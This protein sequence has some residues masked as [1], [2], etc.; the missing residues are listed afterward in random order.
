M[1]LTMV[2]RILLLLLWDSLRTRGGYRS[3]SREGWAF[4]PSFGAAFPAVMM[5]IS[6]HVPQP[7]FVSFTS[8]EPELMYCS[9]FCWKQLCC[10][11]TSEQ[12]VSQGRIMCVEQVLKSVFS[13]QGDLSS[14]YWEL[15]VCWLCLWLSAEMWWWVDVMRSCKKLSSL[16][17]LS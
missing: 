7:G 2:I 11:R 6:S 10:N 3:L 8:T 4:H 12:F 14:L 16:V 13:S 1:R 15:E 5:H 9:A 17:F